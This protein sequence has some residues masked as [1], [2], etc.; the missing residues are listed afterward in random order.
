VRVRAV[1]CLGLLARWRDQ[2]GD[3]RTPH[4][5]TQQLLSDSALTDGL[6]SL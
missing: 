6:C 2:H 3:D 4:A 1:L 5:R